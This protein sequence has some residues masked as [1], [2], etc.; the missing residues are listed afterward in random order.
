MDEASVGTNE[1][2]DGS[3]LCINCSTALDAWESTDV[4][5]YLHHTL[6]RIEDALK[7]ATVVACSTNRTMQPL[8]EVNN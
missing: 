6:A 4:L 5:N 8:A 3:H 2:S 1:P 7:K